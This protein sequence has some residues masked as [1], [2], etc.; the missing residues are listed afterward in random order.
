MTELFNI[1]IRSLK[2]LF[3]KEILKITIMSSFFSTIIIFI[4]LFIFWN[5]LPSLGWAKKIFGGFYNT[6]FN[7]FWTYIVTSTF[8]FLFSPISTIISG[9]FLETVVRKVNL[10]EKQKTINDGYGFFLG[11][12]AGLKILVLSALVYIIILFLKWWLG[13][14]IILAL[15]LQTIAIGHILGKEYYEIVAACNIKKLTVGEFKRDN[16]FNIL[17]T[18]VIISFFFI[19][20]ILNLFAP[21]LSTILMTIKVRKLEETR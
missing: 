3:S 20:P 14:N 8:V 12:I 5:T 21:I 16:Y 10:I 11:V 1:I 19:I 9:L 4:F 13:L 18:G 7:Y 2:I 6:I 15:L 17:T